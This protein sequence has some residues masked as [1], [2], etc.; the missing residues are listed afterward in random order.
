[1]REVQEVPTG[2]RYYSLGIVTKTKPEDT[3]YIMVK[4]IEVMPM[5]SGKIDDE[6]EEVAETH[7]HE[8]EIEDASGVVRGEKVFSEEAIVA[9][10]IR[11]GSSQRI[12][13]DDVVEGETVRIFRYG[14]TEQYYWSPCMREPTIRGKEHVL[15]AWS[16]VEGGGRG[17]E[18][19]D[20][21]SSYWIE[22]STRDK[23]V[24]L[25]TSMNDG[26]PF[27]YDITLD[28]ASGVF[29]IDD[30]DGNSMVLD[31]GAGK[32]TFNLVNEFE[33]NCPKFTFNGESFV[34]NASEAVENNSPRTSHSGE[35]ETEGS[36]T[37]NGLV[38]G[39]GGAGGRA[40]SFNGSINVVGSINGSANIDVSGNISAG[41][42]VSGS[43]I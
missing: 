21:D 39:V 19:F 37:T 31:S 10:W 43:N 28:T 12:S 24:R 7:E 23:H 9:K 40:A 34:S 22:V 2:L 6:D 15:Y 42:I 20:K 14:E 17:E 30:N 5:S 41:G 25:H 18:S 36:T 27:S 35:V 1:M 3:D 16:N 29:S 33:I 32:M 8:S 26:E 38:S 4:P 13:S 11:L